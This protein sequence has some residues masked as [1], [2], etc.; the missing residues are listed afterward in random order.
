[1]LKDVLV[2]KGIVNEQDLNRW[3]ICVS[4]K[5]ADE[6]SLREFNALMPWTKTMFSPLSIKMALAMA[7][8]GADGA[9]RMRF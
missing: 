3:I 6:R 4:E 8:T 5:P 7:A 1:M 2:E 9:T